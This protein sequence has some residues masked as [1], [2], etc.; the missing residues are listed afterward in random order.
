MPEKLKS[1]WSV[2]SE[3]QTAVSYRKIHNSKIVEATRLKFYEH[4]HKAISNNFGIHFTAQI[5]P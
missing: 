2:Q 3:F 1:H 5:M 4:A